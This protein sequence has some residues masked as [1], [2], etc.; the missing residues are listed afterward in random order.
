MDNLFELTGKNIVALL[1]V[2]YF[3]YAVYSLVR[4][5]RRTDSDTRNQDLMPTYVLLGVCITTF[6]GAKGVI[7]MSWKTFLIGFTITVF[8]IASG[9]IIYH[10]IKGNQKDWKQGLTKWS[11]MMV[12]TAAYVSYQLFLTE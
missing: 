8:L 2:V 3:C 4:A 5:Y 1:C 7:S 6:L 11:I 9:K 12:I 10:L